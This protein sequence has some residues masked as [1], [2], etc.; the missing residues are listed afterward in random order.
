M[1]FKIQ[2]NDKKRIA[3]GLEPRNAQIVD[4]QMSTIPED[5]RKPLSEM[6]YIEQISNERVITKIG[7]Y[8]IWAE[9]PEWTVIDIIETIKKRIEEEKKAKER[10]EKENQERNEKEQKEIARI[11]S[12]PVEQRIVRK[13]NSWSLINSY[14]ITKM[15]KDWIEEANHL[16]KEKIKQ[17]EEQDKARV[18]KN[19]EDLLVYLIANNTDRDFLNRLDEGS[20]PEKELLER[21]KE[22]EASKIKSLGIDKYT[23]IRS[24]EFDCCEYPEIEFDAYDEDKYPAEVRNTL[25]IIKEVVTD[26]F[27]RRHVGFCNNCGYTKEKWG[28]RTKTV[29]GGHKIFIEF[30]V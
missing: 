25:K 30:G 7:G 20:L 9:G 10:Q 18:M 29:I 8:S 22:I 15:G 24:D 21:L 17:K 1:K 4:I 19:K 3:A 12:L 6:V 13:G 14:Y 26:S 23:K 5:L 11:A 27:A 16:I 28:I 2:E